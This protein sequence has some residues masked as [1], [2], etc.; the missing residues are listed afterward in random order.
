VSSTPPPT[1]APSGG[2]LAAPDG[3][4]P[5]DRCFRCR[6]PVAA[7]VGLCE[8]HNP[9]HVRG[10]SSTQMHATILVGILIG[11]VGFFILA[12]LAIGTTGPYSVAL[13]GAAI[14]GVGDAAIAYSITNEGESEGVADCR[15]T[16]DG[17]P[18]PDDLAF[19]SA[20]IPAGKAVIFERTV[21]QPRNGT[22]SYDPERLSLVCT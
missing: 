4:E 3:V 19:R 9:G 2:F 6:R 10:P 12:S 11:I 21:A 13:I 15:V 1:D 20:R 5:T 17:V 8:E 18:R 7:G 14:D 22:V 16:R